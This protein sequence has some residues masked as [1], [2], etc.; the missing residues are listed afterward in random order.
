MGSRA[1]IHIRPY[2]D[3]DEPAVLGLLD[4][5]LGSG[6]AGKR[7][8][9][10]FRW[11]HLANPFGRSFMLVALDE[12]RIVGLR[13]FMRWRFRGGA[14][15]LRAVRAVD[16][17]THPEYQGRGIFSRLTLEALEGLRDDTDFV[18]NTPNE[19]SLPGYLKMG[20]KALGE[21]PVWVRIRRPVRFARGVRF[22]TQQE[23]PLG[24]PLPEAPTA[25][26]VL[27]NGALSRLLEAGAPANGLITTHRDLR[28]LRWRYG[29]V[30]SLGYHAVTEEGPG[31]LQGLALFRVRPRGRLREATLA[32]LIVA[33]GDVRTARRL[34][35]AVARSAPVDHVA[36][37]FSAGSAASAARRRG[38]FLR[39]PRGVTF[40]V[41]PI[42]PTLRPD[43]CDMASWALSLGD[44]EVF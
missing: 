7:S 36:C 1:R 12:E 29:S 9:E 15:S 42:K 28:Y 13:A 5:A 27:E 44:V 10:F 39:A 19:R 21:L 18:F 33:P 3:D 2:G 32:E 25:R 35:R 17:S 6:P 38:G 23:G 37:H 8:P 11:K 24:L 20:W 26:E 40:T 43:P 41:Y 4:A 16:T 30:P 14:Q 31:G 22:R 34:L